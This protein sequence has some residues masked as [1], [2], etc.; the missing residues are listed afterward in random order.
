MVVQSLLLAATLKQM[1]RGQLRVL[2]FVVDLP[3]LSK[4]RKHTATVVND[5]IDAGEKELHA[6]GGSEGSREALL[7]C[8]ALVGLA[9][10]QR[11]TCVAAMWRR[12]PGLEGTSL[13]L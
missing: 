4:G 10:N 9:E 2:V 6:S 13:A 3:E 11:S 8:S 1:R 5:H 7:R 12:L